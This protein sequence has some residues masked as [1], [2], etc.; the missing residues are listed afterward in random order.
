MMGVWVLSKSFDDPASGTL[1]VAH[2]Y[3]YN[4]AAMGYEAN[5]WGLVWLSLDVHQLEFLRSGTDPN[6][7][8]V[9]LAGRETWSRPVPLLLETY[10]SKLKGG[11]YAHLGQVLFELGEAEPR[12]L[13]ERDPRRA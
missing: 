9:G 4:H 8:F 1:P 3:G 6:V 2:S 11:P 7:Q 10:A 12:F 5:G 13:I